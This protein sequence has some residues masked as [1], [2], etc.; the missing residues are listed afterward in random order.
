M[1]GVAILLLGVA[2]HAPVFAQALPDPTRPPASARSAAEAA[3]VPQPEAPAPVLQ[4]VLI[5]RDR[6]MAIISGQRFDV[7]D[8]VGDAHIVRIT[9]TEV[10]LRSSAG[11][12]SLKLFPQVE[13]RARPPAPKP[14]AAPHPHK[15]N[16]M[17]ARETEA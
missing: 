12:T 9:E 10:V 7:G 1:P 4:S 5:G 14:G 13:K 2:L 16:A 6:S 15:K 17:T 8:R 11:L 3:G